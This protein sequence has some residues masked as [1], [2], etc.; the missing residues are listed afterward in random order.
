MRG[1]HLDIPAIRDV[2][3]GTRRFLLLL[4]ALEFPD[5]LN[6]IANFFVC[7]Y[8][9]YLLFCE[10]LSVHPTFATWKGQRRILML[11]HIA[12]RF[13]PRLCEK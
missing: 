10:K 13:S 12:R 4:T 5:G 11:V 9:S 1:T 6:F 2:S 3:A 8:V 7:C